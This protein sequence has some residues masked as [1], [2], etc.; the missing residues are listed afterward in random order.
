[1][2]DEDKFDFSEEFSTGEVED[3]F[4][5]HEKKSDSTLAS[6]EEKLV[7]IPDFTFI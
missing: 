3:L 1:M 4:G 5:E 2:K 6:E 7:L